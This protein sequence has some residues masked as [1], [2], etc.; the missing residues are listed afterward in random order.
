VAIESLEAAL[1]FEPALTPA[2]TLEGAAKLVERTSS[3]KG[4]QVVPLDDEQEQMLATNDISLFE[5]NGKIVFFTNQAMVRDVD[6]DWMLQLVLSDLDAPKNSMLSLTPVPSGG[7]DGEA[8]WAFLVMVLPAIVELYQPTLAMLNALSVDQDV[9]HL[10]SHEELA[11]GEFPRMIT[12]WMYIGP[13]RLDR[14]LKR[15][16]TQLQVFRTEPLGEGWLLQVVEKYSDKPSRETISQMRTLSS[17][18]T[19]YTHTS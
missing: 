18:G 19:Q 4:Y 14:D 3:I 2:A 7:E 5:E 17:R 12:P 13:K 6:P 9:D 1:F 16:L 8:N 10:P 15:K 11:P